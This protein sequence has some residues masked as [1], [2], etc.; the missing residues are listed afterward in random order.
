MNCLPPEIQQILQ[1]HVDEHKMEVLKERN[2]VQQDQAMKGLEE[3]TVPPREEMSPN[4][5]EPAGAYSGSS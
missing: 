1:D 3:E 5:Q 2:A 4:G